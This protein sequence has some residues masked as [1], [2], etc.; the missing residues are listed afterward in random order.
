MSPSHCSSVV[1]ELYGLA[2]VPG[3]AAGRA[4]V[5]NQPLSLWGGVNP[6]TAVII[7]QHH[8]QRGTRMAERVLVMPSG[9][10]SSSSSA[11]LVEMVRQ[12]TNP[13]AILL[14]SEDSILILGAIVAREFYSLIVPVVILGKQ[15]FGRIKDGEQLIV[16]YDGRIERAVGHW[17]GEV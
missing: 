13:A 14:A 8:P 11:V 17:S 10:G 1:M 16:H 3:E 9:R 12:R 6:D 15:E 5:L 2:L 7:D 4:L